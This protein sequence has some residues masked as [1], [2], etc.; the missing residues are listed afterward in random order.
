MEIKRRMV[1][2]EKLIKDI[3]S[4]DIRVRILGTVID[5][6]NDSIIIDDGSGKLE[7]SFDEMPDVK[8][9]Q[10][11]RIIARILPLAKGFE[12]RGEVFQDLEGF[13]IKLYKKAKE[14]IEK[15]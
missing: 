6:N 11:V 13:D 9:G 8:T 10:L 1:A 4:Q 15:I 7:I 12:A 2:K 14:T 3:D 5:K